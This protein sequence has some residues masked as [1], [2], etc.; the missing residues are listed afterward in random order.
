VVSAV[1]GVLAFIPVLTPIMAPLA[2]ATAV[3]A[4]ALDATLVAT[5]NGDWKAL[6]V[7]AALMALPGVGRIASEF[8]M[9]HELVP[10]VARNADAARTLT[11]GLR[12]GSVAAL[13]TRNFGR[14]L[15]EGASR[16]P[17]PEGQM[18]PRLQQALDNVKRRSDY[19]GTCGEIK[20]INKALHAGARLDDSVMLTRRVRPPGNPLHGQPHKP[21]DTC[22][23]VLEQFNITWVPK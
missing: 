20:A 15:F 22:R 23:D 19:H 14:N 17:I 16:P 8:R 21:C 18:H 12:P 11:R 1:A 10:T 6:A 4:L 9:A 3:A 7:D 2:A 13:K 5:G